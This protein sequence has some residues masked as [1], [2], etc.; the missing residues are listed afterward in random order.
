MRRLTAEVAFS[1]DDRSFTWADVVAWSVVTGAWPEAWRAAEDGV[2]CHNAMCAG[3]VEPEPGSVDAATRAFRYEHKLLAASE[4]ERW[5]QVRGLNTTDF[6]DFHTRAVLRR[7]AGHQR[8]DL[9]ER[10]E[11]SDAQ[12]AG[13]IRAELILSG[14]LRAWSTALAARAAGAAT[15]PGYEEARDTDGHGAVVGEILG[16][17][18]AHAAAACERALGVEAAY[19]RF[20]ER[21]SV[22]S[23]LQR[24]LEDHQLDWMVVDTTEVSFT[25]EPVAREALLCVHQ[26]G[27]SL[28]Q[29][30]GLAQRPAVHR[31]GLLKD[32]SAALRSVLLSAEHGQVAGPVEADG[33]HL[34]VELVEK[35]R[36]TLDD[37][38]IREHARDAVVR[39]AVRREADRRVT[40]R[41]EL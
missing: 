38:L 19:A 22:D 3:H 10:F 39:R 7:S 26:D 1:V 29:A 30:A 34:L 31:R 37:A 32:R 2:L 13:I 28:E 36:P 33:E 27:L 16:I 23:A 15:V 41:G 6:F 12:V 9:A 40:W 14:D 17:D 11:A 21:V 5:L 25:A 18:E 4:L 20:C 8:A 24:E 35:R